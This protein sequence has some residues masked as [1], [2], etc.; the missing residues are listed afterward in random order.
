MAVLWRPLVLADADELARLYA[1][2][3]EVD[4]TGEHVSAQ[5]LIDDL[6]RPDTEL[7]RGTTTAWLG[8]RL[9]AYG[10]VRRRDEANPV[11][12]V[13]LDSM[14]HPE[15]RDETVAA[16]LIEWFT[17][18]G[19]QMHAESFPDAP[20]ELRHFAHD[21]QRWMAEVL[22]RAGYA[23]GRT[24]LTMRVSLTDLPVQPSLPEGVEAVPYAPEYELATLD[25]RNDTFTGHWGAVT[26][27]PETW[28]H[29]VTG[30]KDFR[31]DLSF[32]VLSPAGD[33]NA[34]VVCHH[35]AA[36]TAATGVREQSVSAVGTRKPLRGRGI[37]SGLIG[38]A[39]RAGQAAGFERAV[40]NVDM[41]NA[42]GA[43]GAYE[44][45]GFRTVD[46]WHA[47]ILPVRP[48]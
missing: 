24:V 39:L 33:V 12:M 11:H 31:P 23:H 20:L 44:R 43:L 48:H 46:A 35:L 19:R 18:T 14:V 30:S 29:V 13:H 15:H 16:H 37:A 7:P 34:F 9:I 27:T 45:C 21:N 32:V 6:T 40:L 42:T 25:A 3:E 4:R 38:R 8:D 2:A 26:F 10:L 1:A 17:A 41:D 28:R 47:Y 36:D 5:N 22:A